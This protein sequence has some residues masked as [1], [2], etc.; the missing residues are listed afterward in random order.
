MSAKI[1]S[2][3]NRIKASPILSIYHKIVSWLES[4]PNK[5]RAF[6]MLPF[7]INWIIGIQT[8]QYQKS[9]YRAMFLS[10]LFLLLSWLLFWLVGFINIYYS[11]GYA[12]QLSAFIIQSILSLT[13]ITISLWLA[14]KEYTQSSPETTFLDQL[15]EKL[16]SAI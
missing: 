16:L 11:T 1:D 15:K 3:L 13:Y 14:Y 8:A 12:V 9:A 4:N 5:V 7:L 2:A 6:C 10:L